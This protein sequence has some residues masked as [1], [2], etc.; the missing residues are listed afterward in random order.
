[1]QASE[2]AFST[3]GVALHDLLRLQDEPRA[4]EL[5]K[6]ARDYQAGVARAHAQAEQQAGALGAQPA[7]AAV[8]R[9][10]AQMH[11]EFETAFSSLREQRER[12]IAKGDEF[13]RKV[14]AAGRELLQPQ[15]AGLPEVKHPLD[16]DQASWTKVPECADLPAPGD[17]TEKPAPAEPPAQTRALA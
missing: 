15:W 14:V 13:F 17:L 16:K 7:N 2:R 5:E 1:M 9:I 11:V 4:N 12:V 10:E 6:L 8:D 3:L